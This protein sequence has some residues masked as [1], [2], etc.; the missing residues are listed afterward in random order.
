MK[1]IFSD[2]LKV[3]LIITTIFTL[4]S[5]NHLLLFYFF[6]EYYRIITNYMMPVF[7]LS[8][9]LWYIFFE[10]SYK[11]IAKLIIVVCIFFVY[12][13]ISIFADI[14]SNI[15]KCNNGS[16]ELQHVSFTGYNRR[17]FLGTK[18]TEGNFDTVAGWVKDNCGVLIQNT[19]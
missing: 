18:P 14:P 19:V 15:S 12:M 13:F 6:G 9:F 2:K 10:N 1:I 7:T 16:I 3:L 17:V 5:F 11:L 8:T 4:I